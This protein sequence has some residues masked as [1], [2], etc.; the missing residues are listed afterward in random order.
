MPAIIRQQYIDPNEGEYRTREIQIDVEMVRPDTMSQMNALVLMRADPVPPPHNVTLPSF[1]PVTANPEEVLGVLLDGKRTTNP[2]GC[3]RGR[4]IEECESYTYL[5]SS[6][7][8]LDLHEGDPVVVMNHLK[9]GNDKLYGL[10]KEFD[11]T[12]LTID[13]SQEPIHFFKGA[14]V[15][16]LASRW[17]R[18]SSTVGAKTQLKR[19]STPTFRGRLASDGNLVE[20]TISVPLNMG[21]LHCYDVYVR[22]HQFNELEGHWLPDKADVPHNVDRISVESYNGGPEAGGG[23]IGEDSPRTLVCVV[24]AKDKNGQK[25]VFESAITPQLLTSSR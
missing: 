23:V 20:I 21:T 4:L 22:D 17:H 5:L 15:Q 24:V 25:D 14:F 16:N 1:P 7:Q 12:S 11:E 8:P 9:K 6:T 19:P 18:A 10:V 2:P 13:S 3:F